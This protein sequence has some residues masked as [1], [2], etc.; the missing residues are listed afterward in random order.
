MLVG[1]SLGSVIAYDIVNFMWN[2]L[3]KDALQ[4]AH[5]TPEIMTALDKVEGA[6]LALIND[7]SKSIAKRNTYRNTQRK[8]FE[9]LQKIA[10]PL[11]LISDL[12]T[13]GSPLSKAEFLLAET[14]TDLSNRIDRREFPTSPPK[15][16]Q[17]N[18]DKERRKFSYPIESDETR[19]PHHAAPFS[20]TVWTNLY[21]PSKYFLYGDII[22]GA[23]SK[24]FGP[25]IR[26]EKIE[27]GKPAGFRHTQYWDTKIDAAV[28]TLRC[29]LNLREDKSE[30]K[31]WER[32]VIDEQTSISKENF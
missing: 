22:S 1:H 31:I 13:L 21:F 23:L 26:D 20:A 17:S 18:T 6:A 10:Q 3:N 29:A 2:G 4:N 25:G 9:E 11:W 8:Y 32:K 15:F 5:I 12:I 7:T 14:E 19:I 16:E 30:D 28:R 27:I 24:R